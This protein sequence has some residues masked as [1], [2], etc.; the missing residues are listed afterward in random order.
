MQQLR[1]V[2]VF[3][4]NVELETWEGVR[5]PGIIEGT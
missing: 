2:A 4:T 3:A 5:Q 1:T